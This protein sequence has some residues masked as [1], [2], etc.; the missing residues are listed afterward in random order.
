MGY[1]K[2]FL[3]GLAF[4]LYFFKL[5]AGNGFCSN[6][7]IADKRFYQQKIKVERLL[8][9]L[10]RYEC[11]LTCLIKCRDAGVYPKFVRYKNFNNKPYKVKNRYYHLILLEKVTTMDRSIDNFKKQLYEAETALHKSTAWLKRLC[12]TYTLS[13]VAKKRL[14]NWK[15]RWRKCLVK[16][17]KMQMFLME[18]ILMLPLPTFLVEFIQMMNMKHFNMV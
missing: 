7:G 3:F 9:N 18:F 17:W 13:N 5:S 8:L 1:K 6:L 12:I 14:E 2:L 4:L 15:Y 16:Y 11:N 10:K